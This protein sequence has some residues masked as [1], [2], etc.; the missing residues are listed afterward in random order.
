MFNAK[1]LQLVAFY[2]NT[3]SCIIAN[4]IVMKIRVEF[5]YYH[6]NPLLDNNSDSI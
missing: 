5:H 1:C 2:L 3:I 4:I 6:I